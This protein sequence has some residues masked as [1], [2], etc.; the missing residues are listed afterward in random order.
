MG[1]I[2][3]L[4]PEIPM[5]PALHDRAADNL[6][7]IRETMERA[8]AFT[9]VPGLALALWSPTAVLSSYLASQQPQPF[10]WL[11][12]WLIEASL[13][14]TVLS[15]AMARKAQQAGQPLS[16]GPGQKFVQG[17]APPFLAAALLTIALARA[18]AWG[19]LPGVWLLLYGAGVVAGGASSV[20]SVPVMGVAFMLLGA[21]ALVTPFWLG[22]LYMALGFGGLH[23][24][25]GAA[26]ARRH[27]G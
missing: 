6:R 18:G 7:F 10:Y 17:V 20:R 2:Q 23:L 11:A 12:V 5:P 16:S 21:L 3:P 9:A 24:I 27:G 8:T 25:F 13:S 1:S 19:I 4:R 26:I 15:A 22:D 14:M